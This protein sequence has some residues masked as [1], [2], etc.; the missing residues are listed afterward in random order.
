M[1]KVVRFVCARSEP[2]LRYIFRGLLRFGYT[3]QISYASATEV[4][5]ARQAGMSTVMMDHDWRRAP[6]SILGPFRPVAL[7]P[8]D[9]RSSQVPEHS[10]LSNCTKTHHLRRAGLPNRALSRT[11][12]GHIASCYAPTQNLAQPR[13]WRIV[14]AAYARPMIRCYCNATEITEANHC[15]AKHH[16]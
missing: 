7:E 5:P 8:C 16:C 11:P 14:L 15:A 12:N 6:L 9:R 13:I 1:T 2:G 3:A 4:R 10:N